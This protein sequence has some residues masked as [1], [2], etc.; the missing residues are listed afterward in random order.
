VLKTRPEGLKRSNFVVQSLMLEAYKEKLE[1]I[2]DALSTKTGT[3]L[4]VGIHL[5]HMFVG[6]F[7]FH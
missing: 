6:Q 3:C 1:S 2:V 5:T 7:L 4:R